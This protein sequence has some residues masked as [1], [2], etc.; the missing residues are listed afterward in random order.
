MSARKQDFTKM[1]LKFVQYYEGDQLEAATKA[2]YRYPDKTAYIIYNRPHVKAACEK[3]MALALKDNAKEFARSVTVTRNEIIN[4]LAKEARQAES[5]SAR[6]A[7]WGRLAEI[8]QLTQKSKSDQDLF[9]G[10]TDEELEHYRKTGKLP[11][12]FGLSADN[13]NEPD[14]SGLSS[15]T[16]PPD[17]RPAMG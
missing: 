7:A 4:G 5:D 3:K 13:P 14:N 1:E 12:R 6:V 9:S 15:G 8:F 10:W 2:G 17:T 16:I 11:A